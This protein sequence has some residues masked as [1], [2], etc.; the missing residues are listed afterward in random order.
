MPSVELYMGALKKLALSTCLS[1]SFLFTRSHIFSPWL[2]VSV[3]FFFLSPTLWVATFFLSH[4]LHPSLSSGATV[5]L[6]NATDLDASREFGQASLI[7]SLEGSSQFRLNSR[8]GMCVLFQM[9]VF[10]EY[11]CC[12]DFVLDLIQFLWFTFEL[13]LINIFIS[14]L[15]Q[16]L[17]V[18]NI[19]ITHFSLFRFVP[20][21]LYSFSLFTA[22]TVS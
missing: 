18:L 12:W 6:V 19:I 2:S 5:L 17:V 15:C 3:H 4:S 9:C 22:Y 1:L 16:L 8:S 7:Y 20:V 13:K 11:F 21:I 10:P 14:L